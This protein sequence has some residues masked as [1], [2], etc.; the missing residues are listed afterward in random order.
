[1]IHFCIV[2]STGLSRALDVENLNLQASDYDSDSLYKLNFN[3][4]K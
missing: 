3:D 2:T 1:M 4:E